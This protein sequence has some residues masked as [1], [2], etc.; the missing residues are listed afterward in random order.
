MLDEIMHRLVAAL[1]RDLH[2][3]LIDMSVARA[4]QAHEIVRDNTDLT[5]KS[6]R[7][8]EGQARFRLM[9]KGFQ[10]A[11]ELHG[12]RAIAGGLLPGTD[13]RFYQPFI[14]FAGE[15]EGVVLGLASMPMRR[16]LPQKNQSRLTGVSLNCA[17]TPRLAL[18]PSDPQPGDVFAL[19]LVARDPARA[20][21]IDEMA[22]GVIDGRYKTYL[23]YQP[24]ETF[25][26]H[27]VSPAPPA[28]PPADPETTPSGRLVKLKPG[29][30]GFRP[31]ESPDADE[32]SSDET[33]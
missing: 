7:G 1:P 23:F 12:G 33:A 22:I 19:F 8:L 30:K 27:Y 15:P 9:E 11:C 26:A 25:I 31:P 13:L 32:S 4:L 17:L 28:L 20:G 29:R 3:D 5:G 21:K 18:D 24:I 16:E 10:D 2:L 14:R 6:A